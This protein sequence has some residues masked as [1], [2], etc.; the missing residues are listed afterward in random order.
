ML[1]KLLNWSLTRCMRAKRSDFRPFGWGLTRLILSLAL[2]GH[3]L[4][5]QASPQYEDMSDSLRMA[6]LGAIREVPFR[7]P[8]FD[9]IEHKVDWLSKMERK[10]IRRVPD[11]RERIALIKTIRYEAQRAGL[12]PQIVF[13][14]IDV[15]SSFRPSAQSNAGAIGLMQ[16]MPFWTKVLS[17]GDK[18]QLLKPSLNIRYGCL[19]LAHYLEIEKGNMQRALARYNGSLGKLVYP[20]RVYAKYNA[21]WRYVWNDQ[22]YRLQARQAEQLALR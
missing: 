6:L 2:A 12:D 11:R 9:S 15:E 13:S 17:D 18:S 7:E 20:D 21:H 4:W 1:Q 14:V 8:V 5:A 3:S 16:I 10:L 22:K 19:I